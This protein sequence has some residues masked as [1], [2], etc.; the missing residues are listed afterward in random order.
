MPTT[1]PTPATPRAPPPPPPSIVSPRIGGTSIHGKDIL[2]WTGGSNIPSR[3]RT[4]PASLLALRPEDFK[5]AKSTEASLKQGADEA[6]WLFPADDINKVGSNKISLMSWM[7]LIR[8]EMEERGM[9]TVFRIPKTGTGD[10]FDDSVPE[11]YLFS[12]WGELSSGQ[13][14]SWVSWLHA[15]GDYFD[16]YNLTLSFKM[17]QSSI[18][19]DMWRKIKKSLSSKPSGPELLTL[20]IEAHQS[21]LCF[22]HSGSRV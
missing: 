15:D 17:I 21:R 2:P 8:H 16:N 20:I 5:S 14:R 7:E 1:P 9:D 4:Q 18:S 19:I 11:S 12:H 6:M 3:N 13:V 10:N 22:G